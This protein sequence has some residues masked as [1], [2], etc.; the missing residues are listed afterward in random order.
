MRLIPLTPAQSGIVAAGIAYPGAYVGV[1]RY[2]L[3]G[4]V[5]PEE[6]LRRL[7]R[8]AQRHPALRLRV[9]VGSDVDPIGYLASAE[10]TARDALSC[11]A[12]DAAVGGAAAVAERLVG[13]V[14][15][16]EAPL[17]R[18]ACV[19]AEPTPGGTPATELVLASHHV[20]LDAVGAH[21]LAC[22]LAVP[23]SADAA[24]PVA[25][26]AYRRFVDW[27]AGQDSVAARDWWSASLGKAPLGTDATSGGGSVAGEVDAHSHRHT[28]RFEVAADE[29]ARLAGLATQ[30]SALRA[31]WGCVVDA[32]E[33]PAL[34]ATPTSLRHAATGSEACV[35]MLTEVVPVLVGPPGRRTLGEVIAEHHSWWTSSLPHHH[36]GLAEALRSAGARPEHVAHLF[37]IDP[38]LPVATAHSGVRHLD[39]RDATH[40]P[41]EVGISYATDAAQVSI[42]ARTDAWSPAQ[43]EYAAALFEGLLRS[44]LGTE[45]GRTLERATAHPAQLVGTLARTPGTELPD[46]SQT[47]AT[48]LAASPERPCLVGTEGY[49]PALWGQTTQRITG[50]AAA[51]RV[52]QWRK[53][54]EAAGAQAGSVVGVRLPRGI[55]VV[56]LL[57]ACWQLRAAVLPLDEA[58]PAGRVRGAVERCTHLVGHDGLRLGPAGPLPVGA[59]WVA[60][61]CL[62][63]GTTGE[64]K[65]VATSAAALSELLRENASR[66]YPQHPSQVAHAAGFYFDAHLDAT[67]A[68]LAGHCLHVLS[69][70][71][72]YNPALL[73]AYVRDA[74]I[75]YLDLTPAVW[76]VLLEHGLERVPEV[77]VTGG[78]AVAPTTWR[79]LANLAAERGG[80]AVNAYGPTEATVDVSRAVIEGQRVDVGV[81]RGGV[82]TEVVGP[83]LTRLPAG[84]PGELYVGGVGLAAG[85]LNDPAATATHFVAAPGGGR[86]YRTGDAAT[87]TAQGRIEVAGRLDD[88]LSLGG[89]R[90]EPAEIVAACLQHD[91]I[92]DAAVAA[93]P[94]GSGVRL[95]AYVVT[96]TPGGVPAD[97]EAVLAQ[98]LPR[99]AIPRVVVS[100]PAIPLTRNGKAD[101]RA[102]A[103]TA[104]PP[105]PADGTDPADGTAAA[106]GTRAAAAAA[107]GPDEETPQLRAVRSAFAATLELDSVQPSSDFFRCGG[108]SIAALRLVACLRDAGWQ[109]SVA[110]VLALRTPTSMAAALTPLAP[111]P[112]APATPSAEQP[113]ALPASAAA[114]LAA[115]CAEEGI[116]TPTRFWH[117]TPTALGMISES[118]KHGDLDPYTTVT[119]YELHGL[120]DS[121]AWP[122]VTAALAAVC[123]AHPHLAAGVWQGPLPEPIAVAGASATPAGDYLCWHHLDDEQLDDHLNQLMRQMHVLPAE[124]ALAP[125][126]A[127]ALAHHRPTPSGAT[128]TL[129]LGLH[130]TLVDGWSTGIITTDL[131]TALAGQQISPRPTPTAYLAWARDERH[132]T[133]WAA[134]WRRRAYPAT[135]V[136]VAAPAAP[137]T[138]YLWT[139]PAGTQQRWADAAAALGVSTATLLARTWAQVLSALTQ[140]QHVTFGMAVAGRTPQVPDSDELVA[141]LMGIVPVTAC[142]SEPDA[143]DL[144]QQLADAATATHLGLPAIVRALRKG[145]AGEDAGQGQNAGQSQNG[146]QGQGVSDAVAPAEPVNAAGPVDVAEPVD[147]AGPF[148][149]AEPFDTVL[150][151]ENLA[152]TQPVSVAGVTVVPVE[153]DDATHYPL[154]VTVTLGD[155]CDVEVTSRPG[156]APGTAK[157]AWRLYRDA[158]EALARDGL[159]AA[160]HGPVLSAELRRVLPAP[161]P[162]GPPATQSHTPSQAP[163]APHPDASPTDAE[164]EAAGAER[165]SVVLAAATE[166]LGRSPQPSDDFFALGGDSVAAMHLAGACYARGLRLRVADVFSARTLTS[167]AHAAQ[168]IAGAAQ[169]LSG[170]AQPSAQPD[171]PAAATA[172]VLPHRTPALAWFDGVPGTGADLLQQ[173]TIEANQLPVG[174]TLASLRQALDQLVAHHDSLRLARGD[175]GR[176][177]VAETAAVH[178][179]EGEGTTHTDRAAAIATFDVGAPQLVWARLA[180]D[181][182]HLVLHHVAVDALSWPVLTSGL[183]ALLAG[184][185]ELP[186]TARLAELVTALHDYAAGQPPPRVPGTEQVS[187]ADEAAIVGHALTDAAPVAIS[188]ARSVTLECDPQHTATCLASGVPMED[189]LLAAVSVCAGRAGWPGLV[190]EVEGHGRLLPTERGFPMTSTIG[191][192]TTTSPHVVP[193]HR[194]PALA[195]RSVRLMRRDAEAAE[196]AAWQHVGGGGED[197]RAESAHV[198]LNYLGRQGESIAAPTAASSPAGP[199]ETPLS[200]PLEL[201][202]YVTGAEGE[203]RLVVDAISHPEVA[204]E[205]SELGRALDDVLAACAMAG[206]CWPVSAATAG[207]LLHASAE[208]DP[209]LAASDLALHGPVSVDVLRSALADCLA[210]HP[211]LRVGFE[212][213]GTAWAAVVT[214]VTDVP[215][216][217]HTGVLSDADVAAVMEAELDRPF[218]VAAAPLLRCQLLATHGG[219]YRLLVVSH[220]AIMDGW[221]IPLFV[222]ELMRHYARRAAGGGPQPLVPAAGSAFEWHI[223]RRLA[224]V[225]MAVPSGPDDD[226][227]S[228]SAMLP[229]GSG[230][231]S[232]GEAMAAGSTLASWRKVLG[233]ATAT[234]VATHPAVAEPRTVTASAEIDSAALA[235]EAARLRVSEAALIA[236]H[237]GRV[238]AALVGTPHVCFGMV[239]AGRAPDELDLLGNLIDVAPIPIG[240]HSTAR[241]CQEVIALA[242]DAPLPPAPALAEL[243]GERLLF[244]TLLTIENY[245]A[246]PPET[247]GPLRVEAMGGSDRTHYPLAVTVEPGE[248]GS[249]V[250]VEVRADLLRPDVARQVLDGLTAA[251]LGQPLPA[252]LGS[253]RLHHDVPGHDASSGAGRL[254]ALLDVCR[255][256]IAADVQPTT[257]LFAAGADSMTVMRLVAQLTLAGWRLPPQAVFALRTPMRIAP[258]M[259]ASAAPTSAPPPSPG[260]PDSAGQPPGQPQPTSQSTGHPVDEF[261]L[262]GDGS[263]DELVHNL[264]DTPGASS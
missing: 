79:A 73:A 171:A 146:G 49:A 188:R 184:D 256:V 243:A 45:V 149:L 106:D 7:E 170:A 224:A 238:L 37:S 122:T 123:A 228:P 259:A 50:R 252:S 234:V 165:L 176:W 6:L 48:C 161:A 242:A 4:R 72:L 60:H 241:G 187:A 88:Q 102:L 179:E 175:D 236:H 52:A 198:L 191:W 82:T 64:P 155:T 223:R 62:T 61:L 43:T 89:V 189:A 78:A 21:L 254:A 8:A 145:A 197:D 127:W 227:A 47:A 92:V 230:A 56:L 95:V 196:L 12:S 115:H 160:S 218:R 27:R 164:A 15:T 154:T 158:L 66:L 1:H 245:P 5:G 16:L 69:E 173:H 107:T 263:L 168:P 157:V 237:Y 213:V 51:E 135:A 41:V 205:P 202:A 25:D 104:G 247:G 108:D 38:P 140:Q 2:L 260:A 143:A 251:L 207:M 169:P 220:H 244:D 190:V 119:R 182:I 264:R 235:D 199:E 211:Q 109:L 215:L 29:L 258:Q 136:C 19:P 18:V 39:S 57:L 65:L 192:F 59:D 162:A 58:A 94:A 124:S 81:P 54:L 210:A 86:L 246:A 200:H 203:Q 84:V 42:S 193:A 76:Q 214:D 194:E 34:L 3:P 172:S 180:P 30:A 131:A 63:S 137:S 53:Q 206:A 17:L 75:D 90:V 232:S 209:Y 105:H 55:D 217:T 125:R 174:V 121:T 134:H 249:Q 144:Q 130:H 177:R 110:D 31:A 166:V 231:A 99:P 68:L 70:E 113:T 195:L 132:T 112:A 87:I 74:E 100:V 44:D 163:P 219:G 26:H 167:I 98:H 114:A 28:V 148:D 226:S 9:V 255:D 253:C 250:S 262:L 153:G 101:L 96:D 186:P 225:E 147:G 185:G 221:S 181:G 20:L 120:D 103:D 128:Y 111:E 46:L 129:V 201:N 117:L 212:Q 204:L 156:V 142:G 77:L 83:R 36:V 85:Y 35:G 97:F 118:R 150:V 139:A 216:Q 222:A 178:V 133:A 152:A 141:L 261:N 93:E 22:E 23:A 33:P 229:Q 239:I 14:G 208:Y 32:L 257:D 126:L 138:T 116:E 240:P 248:Q 24:P 80:R 91:A 183:L 67:L 13:A 151:V 233:G 10:E 40:Y 159:P 11:S 71:I